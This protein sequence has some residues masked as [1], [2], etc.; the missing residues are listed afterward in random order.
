MRELGDLVVD[1]S[2]RGNRATAVYRA[3]LDAMRGGRLPPGERLPPTRAL[4][5]DLGV[6]RTTVAT[7]YDRLVAE[8]FLTARV[9]AGTFVADAAR[10]VRPPRRGTALAPRPGWAATPRPASGG[11]PKP[12]LRLPRRDPRR[13]AVPVRHLA[14]AGGRR[15]AGAARHDLG[16]YADPAGHPRAA[17][18]DRPLRSAV[19]R[20]SR[21]GADDVLVTNGTQQALDLIA[22]VLLAPGRRGRGRGARA[23]RRR[24]TCSRRYGARVVPVPV[25]AEGLVVDALPAAA[26]LVFTHAVAPVPARPADVA[27]P[28]PGAARLRRRGT[29]ARW[30]RTTTT[31]SSGSPRGRWSRCTRWT[32]P[33]RVLYVGTFSKSLLPAL[34]IGFLV[35][36]RRCGTRCA[37]ARSSPTGYGRRA[38]A[39]GAGP[40]HRRGP[41]RPARAQGA[42]AYAERHAPVS[43]RS[44][45]RWPASSCAV[46]AG[47]H[48]TAPAARPVGRRRRGRDRARGRARPGGRGPRRPTR[49]RDAAGFVLGLGAAGTG[50]D[51]PGL[52]TR[53]RVLRRHADPRQPPTPMSPGRAGGAGQRRA[54]RAPRRTTRRRR[55]APRSARQQPERGGRAHHVDQREAAGR[56]SS[57]A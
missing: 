49:R 26:R 56:H 27:G 50:V 40:V 23:T 13:A 9:G 21:A 17:R 43:R 25:D 19:A 20:A 47:L 24:A 4:A 3:L 45:G 5:A 18:G 6:S 16:T 44:T 48:V 54:A 36:A 10:P 41:A 53:L 28:A 33:G 7:A 15:A 30:S 22:R 34:R 57:S 2:V 52:A 11:P 42:A 29:G 55:A 38:R 39:G 51:Q 8:G 14:P 12:A 35:A 1:L 46:P 31:A 32:T 37:A